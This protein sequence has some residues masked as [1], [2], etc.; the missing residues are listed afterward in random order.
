MHN[1]IDS[2]PKCGLK[3]AKHKRIHCELF[4]LCEIL[5]YA[6][7]IYGDR[8]VQELPLGGSMEIDWKEVR[9]NFL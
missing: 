8:S 1:N 6:E 5:E 2:S 3:E 9:E 7:V 4:L